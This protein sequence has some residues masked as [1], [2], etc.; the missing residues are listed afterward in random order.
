V[1]KEYHRKYSREHYQKNKS[2]YIQKARRHRS[3][4]SKWVKSLRTKCLLCG[5]TEICCLDFHH[6][7]GKEAGIAQAVYKGWSKDRIIEEINKCVVLCSNCHRKVHAGVVQ[8]ADTPALEAV[9]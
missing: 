2:K 5:E 4:L 8:L 7:S 3:Q 1:D 6:M 9:C